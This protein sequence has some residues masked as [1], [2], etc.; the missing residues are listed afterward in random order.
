VGPVNLDRR[1]EWISGYLNLYDHRY[2]AFT[3]APVM[4]QRYLSEYT[5][6]L[7]SPANDFSRHSIGF[8]FSH[9]PLG[10]PLRLRQQSSDLLLYENPLAWPM[11]S[12]RVGHEID[13]RSEE[14]TSELQ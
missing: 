2:D 1:G 14:H 3:A 7:A 10:P 4:A 11:A 12:S 8:V 13:G 5:A 6:M 9:Q